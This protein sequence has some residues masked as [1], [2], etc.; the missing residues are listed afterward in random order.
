MGGHQEVGHE[1]LGPVVIGGGNFPE[2][3]ED[4][5]IGHVI[6]VEETKEVFFH[7]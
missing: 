1:G 3:S 6:V 5:A 4:D 7:D 2:R